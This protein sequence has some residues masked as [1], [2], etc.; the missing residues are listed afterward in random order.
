MHRPAIWLAFLAALLL[1]ALALLQSWSRDAAQAQTAE[2]EIPRIVGANGVGPAGAWP[3]FAALVV[4]SA[5]NSNLFA[6]QFCGGDLVA[7]G[8]V[9]TAAHCITDSNGSVV[10]PSSL[11]VVIGR[12]D[13]SATTGGEPIHITQIVRHP[14]YVDA[15][16][17]NDVALLQLQTNSTAPP[18]ALMGSTSS[19]LVAPGSPSVV[20]GHGTTTE[21]GAGSAQL[22]WVVVPIISDATCAQEYGIT[23]MALM[24]TMIC[25]GQAGKDSCQGDSGG[26]LMVQQDSASPWIQIGIVSCGNG[27]AEGGFPRGYSEVA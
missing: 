21:G 2:P 1:A 27:C 5:S 14:S 25:A 26:P 6:G 9:L 24:A 13:L 10:S 20:I 3:S 16:L 23:N 4:R 18:M 12:H 8:W 11:D 17:G 7:P 22:L 15:E 19:P